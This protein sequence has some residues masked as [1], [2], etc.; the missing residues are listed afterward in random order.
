MPH[1]DHITALCFNNAESYEKPI[2]V[3]ASRDGHF[4]VW[5]LTDD[6]DIYSKFT[7]IV[8][9]NYS[10]KSDIVRVWWR[11]PLIPALGRQRQADF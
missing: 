11:T 5:I 9:K 1:D 2:L 10:F 8:L 7:Q 4:K 6:S 3:T